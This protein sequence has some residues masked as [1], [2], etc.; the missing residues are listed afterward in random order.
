M[1]T[2]ITIFY[3]LTGVKSRAKEVKEKTKIKKGGQYED[4][5]LLYK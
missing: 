1:V 5:L 4:Y 3:R 2:A